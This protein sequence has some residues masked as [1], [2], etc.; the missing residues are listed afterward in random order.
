MSALANGYVE[1]SFDSDLID[2]HV[3]CLNGDGCVLKLSRSSTGEEV[4][5]MLSKQLP[6]KKAA[7]LTVHHLDSSLVLHQTL[8]EQGVLGPVATL[9]CVYVPTDLHAAY[10]YAKGLEN[11]QTQEGE[12]ALHGLTQIEGILVSTEVTMPSSLQ[13]LTFA[14]DFNQNLQDVTLPS[15]LQSLTF[16]KGFDQNLQG[17]ALPSSLQ[18]LTFGD[19][20]NQNLQGVTLPSSLQSLTFGDLFKTRICKE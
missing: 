16:G 5:R 19:L 14:Y 7:R 3:Q 8:Q 13:S 11:E 10:C 4:H 6:P 15:S 20:F 2:L 18:S 1:P 17:V 12:L 9:S